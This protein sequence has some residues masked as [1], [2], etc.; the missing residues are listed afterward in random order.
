[1]K[2]TVADDR[3]GERSARAS[4]AGPRR[5]N[6]RSDMLSILDGAFAHRRI[7][8]ALR[9]VPFHP[10]PADVTEDTL[11][12]RR[13]DNRHE[14]TN[15]VGAATLGV[16]AMYML[17]PDKGRRRRAL[18]GDKAYSIVS[19]TR[20][21]LGAAT[22]DAAHRV[23]GLRARAR[24]LVTDAPVP[25]DLQLIERVRAR[26]G[27]LVAHPH[28]IQVGANN[29]R[30]T[31]SGPVL[32]HEVARL[33]DAIRS[34]WGVSTIEDRLVV[35]DSAESISSLQGGLSDRRSVPAF[36]RARWAPALQ[37]AAI[38]GGGLL[39]LYGLRERSPLGLALAGGGLALM[40]RGATNRPL[41]ELLNLD[42]R[43]ADGQ[44]DFASLSSQGDAGMPATE[45]GE[46]VR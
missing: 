40:L 19:G 44:P 41:A 16:V 34:V 30:V 36:V 39:S 33:L 25:D 6:C 11:M 31:L 43:H 21:A 28:A 29:G 2:R 32:A 20:R 15:V 10:H 46:I 12:R 4:V 24:R 22:R 7:A 26:M 38:L 37:G 9:Q 13:F 18:I 14:L 3:C 27:R 17:D 42:A 23:E 5:G 8:R 45:S 35:Y 1:M